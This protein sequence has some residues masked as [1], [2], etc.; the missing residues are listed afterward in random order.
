[1]EQFTEVRTLHT[2]ASWLAWMPDGESVLAARIDERAG[3][4][5]HTVTRWDVATGKELARLPLESQGGWAVYH[6]SPDG[7]TLFAMRCDPAEPCVHAYDAVTGKELFE[8]QGHTAPVFGVAI[9]PDGRTLASGG[10]DHTV[11]LW[12]LATGKQAHVLKRHTREI[13]SLSF[14][15]DGKLLASGSQDGT[16][17]LWDVAN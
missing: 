15:P 2:P 1:T 9:S 3:S 4:G 13:L 17:V 6:L 10:E 11:R 8:P 7:K 16:I 5:P 14:S 12:D